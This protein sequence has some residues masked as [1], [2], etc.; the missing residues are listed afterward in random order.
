MEN[1][2]LLGL[3]PPKFAVGQNVQQF[4]QRLEAFIA[5]QNRQFTEEQT[6]NLIANLLCNRSFDYLHSLPAETKQN[7][8][9][10]KTAIIH[11]YNLTRSA[12][13]QWSLLNNRLQLWNED[14]TSYYDGLLSLANEIEINQDTIL[15]IFLNGLSDNIKHYITLLPHPPG[16]I[17]A[18]LRAAKHFEIVNNDYCIHKNVDEFSK[19]AKDTTGHNSQQD[20]HKP[21]ISHTKPIFQ[22]GEDTTPPFRYVEYNT[23]EF[24]SNKLERHNNNKINSVP[25][26]QAFNGH[27]EIL[28][29]QQ[30]YRPRNYYSKSFQPHPDRPFSPRVFASTV[31]AP[32]YDKNQPNTRKNNY[33]NK[34]QGSGTLKRQQLDEIENHTFNRLPS[35]QHSRNGRNIEI[36]QTPTYTKSYRK[37]NNTKSYEKF[38]YNT[39]NPQHRTTPDKQMQNATS[40]YQNIQT[41]PVNDMEAMGK[42]LV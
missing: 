12:T 23:R 9:A 5:I 25:T 38:R 21:H 3:S 39:K 7:Y 1:F 18:A 26:K 16:N 6:V 36:H 28:S 32:K 11:H 33:N 4:F 31:S 24:N 29:N 10:T 2:G 22:P 30:S 35:I 37:I 34:K 19:P 8:N 41:S 17:Q 14:V 40:R 20:N 13:K 27:T 42:S 15:H